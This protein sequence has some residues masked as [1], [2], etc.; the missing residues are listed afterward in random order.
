M[1]VEFTIP[2]SK[3]DISL[4]T[5]IRVQTLKEQNRTDL[6]I[7]SEVLN[8]PMDI[9]ERF[10]SQVY[11]NAL[12]SI[13]IA[14]EEQP[15]FCNIYEHNGVR[16]GFIPDFENITVGEYAV[17]CQMFEKPIENAL[18]IMKVLYRPI[19]LEGKKCYKIAPYDS[20][21]SA[22][23]YKDF[24]CTL[25]EGS[26]VFFY[27]LGILLSSDILKS[28]TQKVTTGEITVKKDSLAKSGVSIK[29]LTRTAKQQ[30]KTLIQYT[31]NLLT[32]YSFDYRT[33]ATK[34]SLQLQ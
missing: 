13:K 30:E 19:I 7:I 26:T 5:F 24:P 16:Y 9:L 10:P 22:D 20:D 12:E 17:L 32:K 33:R 1:K 27:N 3:K 11:N 23:K 28:M 25:F 21:A 14:L 2:E 6:Q 4:E 18:E 29:C 8:V 15:E 34:Q 31:K